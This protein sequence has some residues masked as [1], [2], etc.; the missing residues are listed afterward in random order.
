M[1]NFFQDF[2]FG[3]LNSTF[4]NLF[5]NYFRGN[6]ICTE[7][8]KISGPVWMSGQT[9]IL[10][11]PVFRASE[12]AKR[13]KKRN[14]RTLKNFLAASSAYFFISLAYIEILSNKLVHDFLVYNGSYLYI[15]VVYNPR[16]YVQGVVAHFLLPRVARW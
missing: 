1:A 9:D 15:D 2:F 5:I 12:V 6:W 11:D 4:F 7:S 10:T 3:F 13:Q 14:L 16:K 8:F